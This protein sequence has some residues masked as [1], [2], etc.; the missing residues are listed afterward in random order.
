MLAELRCDPLLPEGRLA[1]AAGPAPSQLH[2]G[3]G[4]RSLAG[5]LPLLTIEDDGTWRGTR[6]RVR[7]A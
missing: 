7:E 3:A 6:V 5:A 1:L 4:T 2:P